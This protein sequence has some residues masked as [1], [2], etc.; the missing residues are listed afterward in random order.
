MTG[1]LSPGFRIRKLILCFLCLKAYS[2]LQIAARCFHIFICATCF[3]TRLPTVLSRF[4]IS[5]V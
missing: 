4:E 5:Y 3:E 1:A 2:G